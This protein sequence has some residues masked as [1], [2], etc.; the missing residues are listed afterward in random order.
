A[1]TG[2]R[3]Y[4]RSKFDKRI[5]GNPFGESIGRAMQAF[6]SAAGDERVAGEF[7][8]K[9]IALC[10]QVIR[11]AE[12]G[13]VGEGHVGNGIDR[14]LSGKPVKEHVGVHDDTVTGP[15]L[16]QV[17]VLGATGF[18]GQ[19]LVR[20]LMADGHTVRVLVRDCQKLPQE[21]RTE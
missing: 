2:L 12:N 4:I 17:L 1:R 13:Q 9:V 5:S 19:E 14:P 7:G 6:Y 15:K 20:K 18:I 11:V 16:A 21:L 8:A 3:S 10:E